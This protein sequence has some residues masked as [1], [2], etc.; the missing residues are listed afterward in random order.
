MFS[1]NSSRRVPVGF[2]MNVVISRLLPQ[3]Y[4][5]V[6]LSRYS[7]CWPPDCSTSQAQTA[8]GD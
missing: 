5:S 2:P 8:A 7:Y 4:L 6:Q 1:G 3:L